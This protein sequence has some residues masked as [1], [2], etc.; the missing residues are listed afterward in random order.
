MWPFYISTLRCDVLLT[1]CPHLVLIFCVS[2]S[3]QTHL[4]FFTFLRRRRRLRRRRGNLMHL[5]RRKVTPCYPT[6]P[7]P[8]TGTLSPT[9]STPAIFPRTRHTFH[10]RLFF[11][12]TAALTA[13]QACFS[14]L[15]ALFTPCWVC[16]CVF[17]SL[18]RV[19]R[20]EWLSLC[21]HTYQHLPAGYVCGFCKKRRTIKT[22]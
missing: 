6:I 22:E 7:A 3:A 20:Y 1:F 15:F 12:A 11:C 19:I 17:S 18:L 13:I 2:F 10:P 4:N 16:M 8:N 14:F 5:K 9:P 21:V